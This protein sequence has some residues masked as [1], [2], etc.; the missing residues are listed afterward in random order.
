MKGHMATPEQQIGNSN[1]IPK[2]GPFEIQI[3][4]PQKLFSIL[5]HE[6]PGLLGS[7]E[8]DG[9][10][11]SVRCDYVFEKRSHVL[12]TTLGVNSGYFSDDVRAQLIDEFI[13]NSKKG[14]NTP[15]T[16]FAPMLFKQ[17]IFDQFIRDSKTNGKVTFTPDE[18][19][20]VR[21]QDYSFR[22]ET[23]LITRSWKQSR[24]SRIFPS[25]NIYSQR[26]FTDLYPYSDFTLVMMF[27]HPYVFRDTEYGMLVHKFRKYS[28][29]LVES[30]YKA[31]HAK[32]KSTVL[33]LDG[34][35]IKKEIQQRMNNEWYFS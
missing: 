7:V 8:M 24:F 15:P 17:M 14:H 12:V 4:E 11:K 33:R 28:E 32:H 3:P 9:V 29:T 18:P 21:Y 35:E 25:D 6:V 13:L 27:S 1:E 22:E 5:S 19:G 23:N 20:K 2:T 31:F 26:I 30:V 10:L 34:D 16:I